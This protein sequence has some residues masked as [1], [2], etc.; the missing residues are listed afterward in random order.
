MGLPG[1]TLHEVLS[2][3]KFAAECG[4]KINIAQFSPIPGTVSWDKA[5]A[6]GSITKDSDLLITNNTLLPMRSG[7][8][9]WNIVQAVKDIIRIIN[10][11]EDTGLDKARVLIDKLENT[12]CMADADC[13]QM[14]VF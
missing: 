8:F 6:I 2:T 7:I 13:P 12:S 1:Q 10:A 9:T 4:V 3:I 5:I 14:H 11:A